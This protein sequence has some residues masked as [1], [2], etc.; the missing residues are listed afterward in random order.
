MRLENVQNSLLDNIISQALGKK[1]STIHLSSGNCPAL[2]QNG[3]MVTL[4]M[5]PI[6]DVWAHGA[7]RYFL[8]DEKYDAFI[9]T[10]DADIAAEL[11]GYGRFRINLFLQNHGVSIVMSVIASTIPELSEL[12]L[13]Q[14][15]EKILKLKD[16]LVLVTGSTGNGKS[17]TLAAIINE[18][19]KHEK[20]NIITLEDPIEF[21]HT[22]KM[23]MVNHREIG[24]DTKSYATGL[25][26]ALRE[27]PDIILLGEMRDLESIQVAV[28]AAETGHLVLSTLHTL[29]V[30]RTIDRIIDAF[31]YE[32][33]QQIKI[34]LSQVLKAVV[35]QRLLKT[36]DG[37]GR[38]AAAEMMFLTPAISNLIRENKTA[39]INQM[40]QTGQNEGM[41]T[42]ERSIESLR[43]RGIIA[44][45]K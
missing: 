13:P 11:P 33:Q 45:D 9:Q 30:S 5:P 14:S 8:G 41:I 39:H 42:L 43:M 12:G 32:Q 17:T 4:D 2:R 38:V 7:A 6:G 18:F 27:D 26:A 34:Q 29:G 31:P 37:K 40:I 19:N 35:S 23:S 15:M 36:A 44:A 1:A 20:Y 28:T 22:P 16:G 24:K 10:G 21:V 25:R 3:D